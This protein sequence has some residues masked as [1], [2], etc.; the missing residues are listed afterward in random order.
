MGRLGDPYPE[1]VAALVNAAAADPRLEAA[2]LWTHF[3]TADD[4]DSGYFADQLRRFAEMAR[5]LKKKHPEMLLHAANSAATLRDPESHFDMV[6]CGVA[7]YGLD[8]FQGDPA[9]SRLEPA[10]ELRSYVADVK[11]FEQGLERRLRAALDGAGRH[12]GRRAA[13][14]L[15]RRRAA[16]A[17]QQRRRARRRPPPPARRDGLDGQH[18]DR[19]RARDRRRARRARRADRRPGRRADTRRGGRAAPRDDQLRGHVRGLG[20]ASRARTS[21][22]RSASMRSPARRPWRAVREALGPRD[23][24]WIVGG[25]LRDAL[26]GRP[27]VDVDLAV[28]GGGEGGRARASP[29][30]REA[31]RSRSRSD[32]DTWR[33]ESDDRSLARGRHLAARRGDRGRPRRT[34]TSPSTRSRSR[35]TAASRSTR[36][37]AGATP[38]TR[39]S[40]G[41]SPTTSF[42]DDPLRILRAARLAAALGFEIEPATLEL[43]R[44]DA[45]AAPRS[46]PASASSPSC[47][48]SSPAPTRCAARA[49]RRARARPPPCFPSSTRCAA[50]SRTPTT[51]STSTATRSRCCG[52]GSRSRRA[53][54]RS[55]A[56]SSPR[57]VEAL[58]DEPLADE[59]TRR[60]GVRFAA[61]VHDL[62]KP[63]VRR[64]AD[65]GRVLFMGHDTEGVAIVRELCR[66]FRTSRRLSAYL[67]ALTLNHLRLGFLVHA[68]PL[69]R[70]EVYEYLQGNRARVGR[71]DAADGRRPPRDP[72]R[73]HQAGGDR[74]P[75]R[76]RPRDDRRGA[77]V[78]PRRPAA[79]RRSAATSSPP[80]S[81]SR[82]G[83]ELGDAD[84]GDRGRGVRERGQR[85][86][87]TR[88]RWRARSTR[89]DSGQ[90]A[91]SVGCAAMASDCLF[92]GIVAGDVPGADRRLRRAHGRVHGHQP[93]DAAATRWS[94]R[95]ST[96]TT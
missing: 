43:A 36:T 1:A 58:L 56:P 4:R 13:D 96:P 7:I 73:A 78:A 55:S 25:A 80:S 48:A 84:R 87:T 32:F 42:S 19:P 72:G 63:A 88:S 83:P 67:E 27:V 79:I 54:P 90:L 10:M 17:D 94:S 66:R 41:R 35:S 46:P 71:H 69:S 85:P 65:D 11:R 92:C 2:G 14:R 82:A 37:A 51:T 49:A 20:A 70:R 33:A 18:H 53:C 47:A 60:E 75:P 40:C 86:A 31:P 44:R 50:S 52:A 28:A 6:R 89:A 22:E 3:A 24:A 77:R 76:A 23:D 8:P 21:R 5:P 81:A 30:P 95:A 45:R 38:A 12:L 9:D 61:L 39:R 57:E 59:L 68:R 34:A 93:G 62:G 64:V 91:A 29:R 74:R 16:R 15:R 26:L